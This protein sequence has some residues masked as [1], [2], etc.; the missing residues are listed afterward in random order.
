MG[1]RVVYVPHDGDLPEPYTSALLLSG[2]TVLAGKAHVADWFQMHGRSVAWVVCARPAVAPAYLRLVRRTTNAK[3]LY[4][5]HDLHFQREM[6]R[7]ELDGR[8]ATRRQ[9][10][11]LRR[12]ETRI[13]RAVDAVITPSEDEAR[14]IRKIAPRKAVH[15]VPLLFYSP[16]QIIDADAQDPP[17]RR[18]RSVIFVGG[19]RHQPNVDAARFLVQEVMPHIWQEVPDARALLVGSDP[20]AEVLGLSSDRV[21]VT[22]YVDDLRPWYTKA[23]MSISPIRFGAGVKGKL[24]ESLAMGVPVVTTTIGNEGLGL[25]AGKE[26]MIADDAGSIAAAAIALFGD[27]GLTASLATAGQAV[28]RD[29]YSQEAVSRAL[30]DALGPPG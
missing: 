18:R 30:S 12:T 9:A 22:G 17:L 1:H 15:V 23:R 6:R 21:Q 10:E 19:Y 14:V 8:P 13:I 2:I 26:A 7:F 24:L 5:T 16:E 25:V 27:D 28:V 3:L 29:R 4:F 11:A 20:P